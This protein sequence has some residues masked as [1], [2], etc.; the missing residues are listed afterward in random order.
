MKKFLLVF[1]SFLVGMG[2]LVLVLKIVGFQ[3]IKKSLELFR[4]WQLLAILAMSFAMVIF[5][6]WR[7]LEILKGQGVARI[8]FK[9]L[10]SP[11]LAGYSI[12]LLAP[13][14]IWGSELLRVYAVKEKNSI[15]W[16]TGFASVIIE[17]I[18]EWTASFFVVILGMTIFMAKIYGFSER[19]LIFFAVF[20]IIILVI[21]Y[22]YFRI[23]K[24]NSFVKLFGRLLGLE[25]IKE[26]NTL[27]EVEKEI[28]VFFS[29]SNKK[30][31]SALT[32]NILKT[33]AMLIRTWLLIF[34]L[35]GHIGLLSGIS[36]LGFNDLALLAPIPA[37][38]GSHEALQTF[39]FGALGLERSGATAYAIIIRTTEVLIALLGLAVLFRFYINFLRKI[40]TKKTK[41]V[42]I[43]LESDNI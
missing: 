23:F 38:L 20:F 8:S 27:L 32:A 2:L 7:W 17:R 13:L 41:E 16:K 9:N 11:Y 12:M 19:E 1:I 28:F 25:L 26:N 35:G 10:I 24:K 33:L 21:V 30:M 43:A 18:L 37:S 4:F 42:E 3:E 29:A 31:W 40:L 34:F 39:A 36:V 22:F 14:I 15:P 6:I 5:G